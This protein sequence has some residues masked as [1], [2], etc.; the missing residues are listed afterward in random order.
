MI[1][2]GG[3]EKRLPILAG[4]RY[5][6]R[7]DPQN[8]LEMDLAAGPVEDGRVRV[9]AK[10][11]GAGT[12]R[13]QLRLFN[14][15]LPSRDLGPEPSAPAQVELTLTPDVERSLTWEVRIAD[16]QKPWAAVAVPDG[17]LG[18]KQEVFGTSGTERSL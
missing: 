15:S 8:A 11:R 14:G 13:V 6:L 2:Y 9:T 16:P 10:V 17:R 4:G 12:H 3:W 7:L 1:T 18:E 5:K